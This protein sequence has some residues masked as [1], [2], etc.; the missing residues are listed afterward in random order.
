MNIKQ[1]IACASLIMTI[2]GCATVDEATRLAAY[3]RNKLAHPALLNFLAT[4]KPGEKLFVIDTEKNNEEGTAII[5]DSY[6]AA[7]GK[8]CRAYHWLPIDDQQTS[9]P[10]NLNVACQTVMGKWHKIRILSNI[11]ALL[12]EEPVGYVLH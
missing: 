5:R 4:G 6:L 2:S 1:L 3:E 7:S 10:Q 8:T 11:E 12:E 9:G